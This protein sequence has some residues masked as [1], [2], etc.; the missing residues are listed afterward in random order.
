MKTQ[1][2]LASI[3]VYI[4]RNAAYGDDVLSRLAGP[5]IQGDLAVEVV[6]CGGR[7]DP[8]YILKAFESGAQA[9]LVLACP[10][11]QCKSMEGNLRALRRTEVVRDLLAEIGLSPDSVQ[12]FVPGSAEDPV[13]DGVIEAVTRLARVGR[14]RNQG[15]AV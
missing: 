15:A 13:A 1:T 11:D 10:K 14:N 6:P 12:V 8:R 5:K 9:V 3:R 2:S 4:C 7:I